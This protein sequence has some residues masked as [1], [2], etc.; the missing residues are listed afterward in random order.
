MNTLLFHPLIPGMKLE[1]DWHSGSVPANIE[2]GPNTVIDTC[3]QIVA[4][5]P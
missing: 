3:R 5:G 4:K 1:C 2:V